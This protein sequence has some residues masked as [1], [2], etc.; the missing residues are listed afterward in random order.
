MQLKRLAASSVIYCILKSFSLDIP[1]VKLRLDPAVKFIKLTHWNKLKLHG[2]SFPRGIL[3]RISRGC[4]AE[5]GRMEFKLHRPPLSG[6]S[7]TCAG[8]REHVW[9]LRCCKTD[10]SKKVAAISFHRAGRISRVRDKRR[11]CVC[12]CVCDLRLQHTLDR[13]HRLK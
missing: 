4:Y 3:A 9:N 6:I 10:V 7:R 5:N 8:R 12:V 11:V 1:E 2:S 13:N